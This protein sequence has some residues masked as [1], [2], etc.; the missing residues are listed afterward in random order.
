MSDVAGEDSLLC[1]SA[2]PDWPGAQ[3][4]G[5]VGG[6]AHQPRVA[7]LEHPV[8][9]SDSLLALAEPVLPTEVFR[10]A[11]SCI[12]VRCRHFTEGTCR[13]A[14]KVVALLPEQANGLPACHIRGRCRWFRQEGINACR[15]CPMVAT[16]DAN[17]S[18]PIRRAADPD[19]W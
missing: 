2:Q 3:A 17:P 15:R 8:P 4:I 12:E 13:L 19:V 1:P 9:V 10:F 16:H 14:A 11:A 6:D 7:Y 5:V 18:P